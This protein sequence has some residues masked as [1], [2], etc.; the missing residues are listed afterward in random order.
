MDSEPSK[1][2]ENSDL[3]AHVGY[4]LQSPRIRYSILHDIK[5]YRF[6]WYYHI[7]FLPIISGIF[8]SLFLLL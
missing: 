5:S 7:Y 4:V 8:W 6:I 1:Q 3:D 2:N